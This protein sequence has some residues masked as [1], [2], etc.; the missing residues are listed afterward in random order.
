MYY[1]SLT[2]KELMDTPLP[3]ITYQ[4]RLMF[5]PTLAEAKYTYN[6]LNKQV[7]AGELLMPTLDIAARRQ[8]YWG[9]CIGSIEQ[10]KTGSY[11]EIE[12]MDKW[13]CRQWFVTILAH[14]MA[15]QHQWDI[16]G[17]ARARQ[18]KDWLMSHGP[19]FFTFRNR[20]GEHNIPLKTAHRM[21]KWFK[22]Q[23]LF[24]T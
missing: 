3:P 22:Y 7:F 9:M 4:R 24:K 12:L 6:L 19:S 21:R 10:H 8:K 11:C 2:L 1:E 18:G 17:P 15:H 14:E 13:H 5:R 23:D 20:L 16:N